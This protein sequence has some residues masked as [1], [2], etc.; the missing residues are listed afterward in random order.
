MVKRRICLFA[1]LPFR[2]FH[3]NNQNN[4]IYAKILRTCVVTLHYQNEKTNG[5]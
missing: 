1:V 5:I 3:K 4:F 2:F